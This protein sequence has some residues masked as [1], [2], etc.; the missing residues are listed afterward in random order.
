MTQKEVFWDWSLN[1]NF[2][3]ENLDWGRVVG[4][5]PAVDVVLVD[6]FGLFVDVLGLFVDDEAFV[7]LS[8][9]DRCYKTFYVRDFRIFVIS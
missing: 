2:S 5:V 4:V 3:G 7:E 9:W 6:D 1:E 8:T